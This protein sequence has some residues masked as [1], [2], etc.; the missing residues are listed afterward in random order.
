MPVLLQ[1]LFLSLPMLLLTTE[2]L[3]LAILT[4]LPPSIQL[5]VYPILTSS[6]LPLNVSVFPVV[7]PTFSWLSFQSPNHHRCY[8]SLVNSGF[9]FDPK[10]LFLHIVLFRRATVL[11][12]HIFLLLT[13]CSTVFMARDFY[14]KY[15]NFIS[16]M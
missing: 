4:N 3:F 9:G 15:L 11:I 1:R 16:A 14:P 7:L 6:S 12:A 13:S 5:C 2:D 8:Y 10:Y